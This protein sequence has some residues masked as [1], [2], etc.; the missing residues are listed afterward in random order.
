MKNIYVFSALIALGM[1][2]LTIVWAKKRKL[3]VKSFLLWVLVWASM[4]AFSVFP[5]LLFA[6]MDFANMEIRVYFLFIVST[7]FIFFYLFA[8]SVAERKNDRAIHILT[9]EIAM[10]KFQ[11]EN[12]EEHSK[13]Q[14]DKE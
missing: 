3:S 13:E 5:N 11:V 2:I 7:L 4:F 6:L 12:L 8:Q 1:S 10:L 14:H 9:Q